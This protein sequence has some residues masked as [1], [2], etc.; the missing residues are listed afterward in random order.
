MFTNQARNIDA[1]AT[2]VHDCLALHVRDIRSCYVSCYG[3]IYV[4]HYQLQGSIC[5]YKIHLRVKVKIYK[6]EPKVVGFHK[7]VCEMIQC[8]EV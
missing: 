2:I 5:E 6:D 1:A 7:K 4:Q 3:L 8:D